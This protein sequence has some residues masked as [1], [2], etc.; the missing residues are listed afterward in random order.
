[1]LVKPKKKNKELQT[2]DDSMIINGYTDDQQQNEQ[3]I[4]EVAKEIETKTGI[5]KYRQNFNDM[6]I[7]QLEHQLDRFIEAVKV[8]K[9]KMIAGIHYLEVKGVEKPIITKQ[10]TAWLA[11]AT[12]MSVVTV[13]LKEIIDPKNDFIFY[14]HKT[15]VSWDGSRMVS[16]DGSAN[17]QEYNQKQKYQSVK[18]QKTVFDTINDVMQMSQKRARNQAIKELI[19][20]TDIF[21]TDEDNPIASNRKQMGIYSL[22]YKHFLTHAPAAPKKQKLKNGKW[23]F[24]VEKEKLNWQKDYL[25]NKYFTPKIYELGLPTYGNWTVM[26]VEILEKEIP[27]W[28]N[29]FFMNEYDQ[30]LI[31]N[32]G[33]GKE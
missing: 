10:G 14:K 2:D 30:K 17:S 6:S 11:A 18:S 33:G 16:A 21:E 29:E 15:T 4:T 19:A 8:I 23:K 25:K 27:T 9:K 1:M 26:D 24:L 20:M 12:N 31:K 28:E 13:E 22:F 3:T 7:K 32:A 5:A